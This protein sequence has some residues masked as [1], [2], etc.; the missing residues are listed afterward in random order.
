MLSINTIQYSEYGSIVILY[1]LTL[2]YKYIVIT[3]CLHQD[4]KICTGSW[5]YKGGCASRTKDQKDAHEMQLKSE[6]NGST[7]NGRTTREPPVL[8]D[9]LDLLRYDLPR[10]TFQNLDIQV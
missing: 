4:T 2:Q 10:S 3:Q 8:L 1:I 6:Q 5:L 9:K 7:M